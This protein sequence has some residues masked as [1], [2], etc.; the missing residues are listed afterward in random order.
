MQRMHR[1]HALR[2]SLGLVGMGLLSACGLGP[3]SG[4]APSRVRRIGVLGDAPASVWDA[5]LEGMGEYGWVEGKN[6][7]IERR[8]AEGSYARFVD[9][10]GELAGLGVECIVA[11]SLSAVAAAKQATS[12]VPI[13]GNLVTGEALENGIVEN[14]ARPGGNVTGS[15]GISGAQLFGKL[16]ELLTAVAPD[17]T[18]IAA[19]GNSTSAGFDYGVEAARSAAATLGLRLQVF[20]VRGNDELD[21]AFAAMGAARAGALAI[22]HST[23][24]ASARPKLAEL[25]LKHR[26]ASI[27]NDTELPAAGGLLAYGVNRP[28]VY[29]YSASYVDKIL[30]GAKPGDLPMERPRKFDL[31]INLKTARVLGLTI[32][33]S[34]LHQATELIQ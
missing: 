18:L 10:T 14:I 25:G 24:F 33:Q 13:V 19:L 21:A 34:V 7:A 32:P 30:K 15:A 4:P 20:A 12:T 2:G 8:W 11:G 1:R 16:L 28:D 31:V 23:I 17:A 5:F 27:T 6:L 26:L 22:V 9:L 29:R 3:I